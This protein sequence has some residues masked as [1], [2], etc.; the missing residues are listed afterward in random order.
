MAAWGP[1]ERGV[2]ESS[3]GL[4]YT[5]SGGPWKGPGGVF[6]SSEIGL[7]GSSVGPLAQD[8]THVAHCD[9]KKKNT[10]NSHNFGTVP[11]KER[12]GL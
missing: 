11:P 1:E 12:Q 3:K 9:K 6:M 8:T 7:P 4:A 2:A 5:C 10:E